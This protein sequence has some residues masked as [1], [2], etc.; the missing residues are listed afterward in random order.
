MFLQ[1]QE[2]QKIRQCNIMINFEKYTD[3]PLCHFKPKDIFTINFNSE[4]STANLS[5]V[6]LSNLN[7]TKKHS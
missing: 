5:V 1:M 6:T 4:L 2:E 3:Q 7:F